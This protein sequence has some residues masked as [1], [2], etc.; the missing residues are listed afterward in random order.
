[1]RR[2]T[3]LMVNVALA[4]GPL[5]APAAT[6]ADEL[7]VGGGKIFYEVRGRGPA[8]VLIHDGLVHREGWDAQFAAFAERY[9]VVRYDRRG[10]GK[11]PA[12]TTAYSDVDD[13]HKLLKHLEV[14]RAVVVGSSA[15][16]GLAIDFTL[17]H[18]DMVERL[19]LVGPVVGGMRYS[20]HF[21]NRNRAAMT[22]D[23][24]TKISNWQKDPYLMAA[25]SDAARKRFGDLL[26]ANPQNL[27]TDRGEWQQWPKRFAVS[28]LG[29][30]RAPTLIIVGE[31][32][33]PD[34]HAQCGA[35]E[36]GIA[37]IRRVVVSKVGH[38][39]YMER[40][41]EFNKLVFDYLADTRPAAEALLLRAAR[42]AGGVDVLFRYR[43]FTWNGKAMVHAGGREIAIRGEW[44]VQPPE[45]A[46][47]RTNSEVSGKKSTR[48]LVLNGAKGWGQ[49][50]GKPRPLEADFVKEEHEQFYLYELMRL[51]PLLIEPEYQLTPVGE[52]GLRVARKGHVDVDLAFDRDSALLAKLT[53]KRGDATQVMTLGAF[54]DTG[55]LRWPRKISIQRDGKPFFDLEITDFTPLESLDEK[56]FAEP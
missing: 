49:F 51:I 7:D 22:G 52:L 13:L 4:F 50:D 44:A 20:D 18:P 1:M 33:I 36:A 28:R 53:T 31:S 41:D 23:V 10:Y 42:A 12:P 9:R 3:R 14:S 55:G 54:A 56:L 48:L 43:A 16:G 5:L 26:A 32:D 19:V 15:G 2:P 21:Q 34:V 29:E 39:V 8:L 25:G 17:E 40:P 27:T 6:F 30:I 24:A 46:R 11:S 38:L 47:V 35:I 45:R 37:G